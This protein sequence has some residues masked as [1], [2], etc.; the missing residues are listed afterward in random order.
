MLE[1]L[2]VNVL[3]QTDVLSFTY[4]DPD[5]VK[6]ANIINALMELY[7]E[8]K[9]SSTQVDSESAGNFLDRQIPIT[10]EQVT[11]AENELRIFRENYDVVDLSGE[12]KI[13]VAALNDFRHCT[14]YKTIC[15]VNLGLPYLTRLGPIR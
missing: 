15:A 5:P 9:L 1:N 11:E 2:Q 13:I 14:R 8:E 12:Q 4:L 7:R 3:F 10:A 6:A